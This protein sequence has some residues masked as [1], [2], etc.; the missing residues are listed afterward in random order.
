[1][2]DCIRHAQARCMFLTQGLR[3]G[4]LSYTV[5]SGSR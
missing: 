1:M 4:T 3:L 2:I 5:A